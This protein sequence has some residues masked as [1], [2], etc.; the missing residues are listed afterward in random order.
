MPYYVANQ[1]CGH[2]AGCTNPNTG[3]GSYGNCSGVCGGNCGNCHPFPPIC[4]TGTQG[5]V[6]PMGPQGIQGATGPQGPQGPRGAQGPQGA[7]GA[8]GATGAT[9]PQG[10]QGIQGVPGAQ[11]A[12]GATGPQ[13]AQG[14]QGVPGVPGATGAT[15][16]AELSAY[17]SGSTA[18][19]LTAT[20]NT[21]IPYSA[22]AAQPVGSVVQNAGTFTLTTPGTYWVIATLNAPPQTNLNTYA[23]L[24]SNGAEIP[25]T[26]TRIENGGNAVSYV[27]QALVTSNGTTTVSLTTADTVTLTA[28]PAD[29]VTS[30]SFLR[31]A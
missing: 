26:Q 19:T 24:R 4:P 17:A 8:T 12:T 21:P 5:P 30:I 23:V 31:I 10:A 28:Q 29:A 18:G 9:G 13:G 22:F 14:I 20:A 7:Q 3:F 15:G 6:G 16:A 1:G 25:S 11:G 27:L 2:D